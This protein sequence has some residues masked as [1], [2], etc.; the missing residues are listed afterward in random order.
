MFTF[1]GFVLAFTDFFNVRCQVQTK[2]GIDSIKPYSVCFFFF[3]STYCPCIFPAGL[4]LNLEIILSVL[5]DISLVS[6]FPWEGPP[7]SEI[8]SFFSSCSFVI[9]FFIF[10]F[11][12]SW[13][14]H[15]VSVFP[16][17]K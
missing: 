3:C 9:S 17:P 11:L 15:E 12:S 1:S 13:N 8:I 16:F 2:T 10:T 6:S 7:L 14:L 5:E 4:L